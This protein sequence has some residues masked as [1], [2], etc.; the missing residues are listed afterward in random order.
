MADRTAIEWCDATFNPWIGC[1]AISPACDHCYAQADMD[2]RRHRV[3]WGAGQPRSRTSTDYWKKPIRWNAQRFWECSACGMRGDDAGF[4]RAGH[5]LPAYPTP[6]TR[7]PVPC[8]ETVEHARRRVFCASLADVFD[9]E[10]DPGWRA[11]LFDLIAAT[12]N[13]DWLLLTKRIGNVAAMVPGTWRPRYPLN[14]WLG[15][16]IAN[17]KEM[18]RD[19]PKLQATPASVRF[20]SVEPM[21]DDLGKI[22]SDLF[23]DWVIA[24]GE[25]GPAARPLSP[26]WVRALRDQCAAAVVPF[27]FK[28]WGEWVPMLGQ[29][30]GV[31]VRDKTTSPDGWVMGRAGKKLAGRLLDGIEH[32]AFPEVRHA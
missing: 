18:L 25:S 19:A 21:L 28:Q 1:T 16:T 4:R 8:Y 13:L 11:D 24:G 30:E 20:W 6:T 29:V 9:N 10:V 22:P 5:P 12:P 32:N 2:H 23:P 31:P 14:V 3:R 27:L 15:G 7:A 17:R 26:D